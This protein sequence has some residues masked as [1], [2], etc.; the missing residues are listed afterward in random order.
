[1]EEPLWI[2]RDE[3]HLLYGRQVELFGGSFGVRDENLVESA[4]HRPQM[5]YNYEPDADL[6]DLAAA[7]LT[8]FTKN[9]G[10]VDGN[11]RI[12]LATTLS[13]LGANGWRVS[14]PPDALLAL[15]L[16]VATSELTEHEAAAWLRHHA[17][18]RL[19]PG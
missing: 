14:T 19:S 9:H 15:V 16:H 13:F 17:V 7:Y 6:F 4:L 18:P 10:F 2:D 3:L 8:G 12:G 1:M 5:K 11:K